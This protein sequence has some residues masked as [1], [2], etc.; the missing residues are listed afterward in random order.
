MSRL[1]DIVIFI[2]LAACGSFLT[3]LPVRAADDPRPAEA[4]KP[5]ATDAKPA[6]STAKPAT[7]DPRPAEA[8]P[9]PKPATDD[10]APAVNPPATAPEAAA[11]AP[12]TAA[13]VAPVPA[14]PAAPEPAASAAP[15]PAPPVAPEPAPKMAEPAPV[16]APEQAPANGLTG[17]LMVTVGKSITIDSPLNIQRVYYANGDLVEAVA[18][19]PK[20]VLITGKA[21]GVTTLMVWQQNGNRM[22]YELTVRPSP[23]KLDAIR[24]QIARD[25]PDDD[26]NITWDND[27]AFVRGTVKDVTSADRIM[28]M[29]TTLGK[30]INLLRVKVPEVEP[31]ILLKVKFADVDRSVSQ[32]LGVNI[33]SAA[34]NQ[35]TGI[36]TG[37]FGQ[38]GID[39]FGN[40]SLSQALNI[41]LFRK[42]INLGATIQALE[43]KNLLQMLSEPNVLAI[44]GQQASFLSGGQ[45]PIPMVQGSA[46]LGTV[47]IA[48]K[49]YGIRLT[50]L[51]NIT[52][53]GT[54]R[55]KVSPEV[56]SL[57]FA[58]GVQLQGFTVPALSTRRVDTEVELESGQSFVIAGLLDNNTTENLSKIPGLSAIP[59]L[60]KLF[61]SRAIN[62]KNTELMVIVTPEVV[63]PVQEQQ[64]PELNYP[65]S[66][67][68]QNTKTPM[69]TPGM[70][71]TGP[72]PTHPPTDS[73]PLEQLL[74][75]R[76][77]GQSATPQS[78]TAQPTAPQPPVLGQG[79]APSGVIK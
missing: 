48:F 16:Q 26:I 32:T 29:V 73:M 25:Y 12:E 2:G 37:Q 14:A 13:A 8:A 56:S 57:D 72:V 65:K 10:A 4:A 46:S 51:P 33:A 64:V 27:T 40:F 22:M 67:L 5:A 7:D 66:F 34:F 71:K 43:G 52:P 39:Q 30:A 3:R 19:N 62:K 36:T 31:Q 60:G 78:N 61:Q 17:N 6:D 9:A 28:A 49:E 77:K 69:R 45:F 50:F 38:A 63:R 76:M 44:N 59:V 79:G 70:D 47:T 1:R 20:E 75:E 15:V 11:K 21:P 54:I 55:L 58:N 23:V 35:D 68:P 41:L 42:D 74:Q 24:Q 18:I 53:R